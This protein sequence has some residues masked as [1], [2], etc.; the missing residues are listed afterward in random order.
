MLT[1]EEFYTLAA[2]QPASITPNELADLYATTQN[3]FLENERLARRVHVLELQFSAMGDGYDRMKAQRDAA[4][5]VEAEGHCEARCPHDTPW[6]LGAK[7]AS[8][9]LRQQNV[10]TRCTL[11]AGHTGPHLGPDDSTWPNTQAAN[12]QG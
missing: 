7:A 10:K 4:R 12:Q 3:L 1:L 9:T 6:S 2:R 11:S 8:R 5:K